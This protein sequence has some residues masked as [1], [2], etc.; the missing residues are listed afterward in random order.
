MNRVG[1]IFLRL[2]VFIFSLIPFWLLYILSDGLRILFQYILKYRYK[3]IST[4]I[5]NSFP[6]KEEKEIKRLISGAY[7]NLCDVTLEGIKGFTITEDILEIRYKVRNPEV[8]LP[9]YEA[10]REVI[11][12]AGHY[13]NWEWG[14]TLGCWFEHL[15][16]GVYQ[17]MSNPLINEYIERSRTRTNMVLLRKRE[18]FKYLETTPPKPRCIILIADQSPTNQKSMVWMDFLNQ[19]TAFAAGPEQLAVKYNMPV[20]FA[21]VERM[22]R[23][24]YELTIHVL[25]D[26][27][28]K[29]KEEEL[30]KRFAEKIESIIVKKPE[31]WLWSHR[32]WK[33]KRHE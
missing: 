16:I 7:K 30:T 23:G 33:R 25:T 32:R 6:D 27:P 29:L 2:T 17:P 1:Y 18:T 21:E 8:L 26:E 28:T 10:G 5:R 31:N 13:G 22:K 12:T 3:V 19:D 9:F 20:V 14:L 24:Y 15:A 11:L 4:N